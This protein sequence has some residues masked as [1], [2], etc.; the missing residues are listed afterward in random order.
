MV[1]KRSKV[2]KRIPKYGSDVI[3][4][5][6]KAFDI[7]YAAFNPGAT[8]R[9]IHDSI[10]NYGGNNCPEVIF[11]CHEEYSVAIAHGYAKAKGKPMAAIT[12]NM[13]G[14]QHASMAIFN[15]WCD[16]VPVIVLGGTG[17]MD[18]TRRRPWIDWIHTA[19][20]QGNQVRDYVKW[21][22]QPFSLKSVPESFIRGYR[23]ATTE[24]KAP[25]YICYDAD[26]QEEAL[27]D[28]IEI[29]DISRY[30]PPA[31]MQ[32]NPESLRQAA[33]LLVGAKSP[34]IIADHL[35]RNHGAVDSLVKLAELLAIPV[36]DKGKRFNFPNTHPLDV[37]GGADEFLEK[38]DVI[39]ALDVPDIYGSLVRLNPTT[40]VSENITRP[41]VKIIHI[42]MNDMLIRSWAHDYHCLPAVDVPIGADTS[43]AVPELTLLCRKLLRKNETKKKAIQ[44]RFKKITNHHNKLRNRWATDARL[45][46]NTNVI[47]TAFLSQELWEVIRKE[48][49]VLVN[50]NS[51]GWVRRLWDWTKPYQY[52]GNSGGGGI[53]YGLSAAIG[54]ALAYKGTDKICVDIQSD[55][56]LL[57]TA[58][59][60][61]TAAHHK[62]P[63]LIVMHNNRSFY[64][65]EEHNINIAKFRKRPVGL[66][67]IGTRVD[68]PPVNFKQV[69]EGFGLYGDGP[70]TRAEDLRPALQ[71]A[72]NV[73]KNQKVPALVDVVSAPR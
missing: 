48:D 31:P 27:T 52:S 21:D 22:D 68:T 59:A 60:L 58:S 3:V 29:P 19:L 70:I 5:L 20:V 26:I 6:M 47:S 67:G 11:C 38:A 57:M 40:R 46:S 69:A 35:G 61:Y 37:T 4:E 10:L 55:G 63:L 41:A 51:R 14:L 2:K 64:N 71:K 32:A 56:D 45:Q 72:L 42:S 66:A 7:E 18:T 34:L 16:R 53:G 28:T 43:I 65:S 33:D 25:V 9:G 12:H 50:Y 54:A 44:A 49:W 39:L 8:F 23:I 17:P 30:A 1:K 24:P 73:V 62:I 13:V 36:I 15:A